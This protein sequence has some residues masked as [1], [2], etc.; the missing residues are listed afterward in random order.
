MTTLKFHEK[1]Y[2]AY[3]F[4]SL[5]H[6]SNTT[7]SLLIDFFNC[8]QNETSEF[9]Q[10][11]VVPQFT[12]IPESGRV[13][14]KSY[15]RGGLISCINKEK[16]FNF[17]KIRSRKE[18]EFFMNAKQAGVTVPTPV[19]YASRGFPFY[20]AWL[21]TK[22]IPGYS[23]FVEICRDEKKKAMGLI[24]EISHNIK[25]LIKNAIHHVDLHPGNILIDKN[26]KPHII[27]FD[28]A[29]YY[30]KD[31]TKLIKKYQQ[32]WTKAIHK[33]RLPDALTD[34]QLLES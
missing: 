33:Y 32:R 29:Y 9:L 6:L 26:N 14:V 30:S 8:K 15:K 4:G 19:V 24:P 13:V 27:D 31:K 23:S 34:L 2:K 16:Y 1:Q 22:E 17:G 5:I 25:L 20:K 7:L 21:V 11:R 10:G 12:S 18:F 28:K 3:S